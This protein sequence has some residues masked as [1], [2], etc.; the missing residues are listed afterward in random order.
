MQKIAFI[1]V[2]LVEES[3]QVANQQI[4][5]EIMEEQPVIPYVARIEK[6][7]VLDCQT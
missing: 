7:A 5:K 1:V 3:Q 6:V 4:E 2:R